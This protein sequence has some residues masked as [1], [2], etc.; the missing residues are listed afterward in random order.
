MKPTFRT[1]VLTAGVLLTALT[2]FAFSPP[3][4]RTFE[5]MKNLDIFATLFKE[6]NQYYVDDIN[7]NRAIRTGIEAMLKELDP[8]TV[9]YPEDDI[10]DYRTMTTGQYSGIGVVTQARAGKLMITNVL[11][12]TPAARAGLRIGDEIVKVDGVDIKRPGVQID[13]LMKG[14]TG[15][16]VKLSLLRLGQSALEEVTVG[17]DV[18]K[19][20][21]VPYYGM[22]DGQTGYLDL[23][24]FTATASKEIKD[25]VADLKAKGMKRLVLDLRENPGGLLLMAVDISNVFLPKELPVVETKGKIAEWNKVYKTTYSPLDTEL[26]LIVL[27]NNRSASAAEI[28]AGAIQDYDRGVLVG[29]RSFGKGL[30]QI[31]RDLSYNTKMKVTTAKYYIPSGRCIQAIDYS[32]RNPDGSVGKIPDSLKT[33]FQT[34]NSKRTVYDGGGILP[35]VAVERPQQAAIT[36]SLIRQNLIFDYANRYRQAHATVAPA[37]QF[38]LTDAEYQEFVKWLADKTYDYT[39]EVEQKVTELEASARK[40]GYYEA[41]QQQLTAL[42]TRFSHNKEND[43]MKFRREIQLLLEQEIVQRY[44]FQKGVREWSFENDAEIRAGLAV[45]N[46]PARYRAILSGSK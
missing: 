39:T 6:L 14:Q 16:S 22:I 31:G 11:E 9:F 2:L 42:K 8:Y 15:S 37:R 46:D 25:A 43:L 27:T 3:A 23:K 30:V 19:L 32:H 34:R 20:T 13:R 17:R 44:Y 7:P 24:G 18:V 10:E 38:K 4:D 28:V 33:A 1:P 45:L 41:V 35:D 29:Q 5:I 36:S 40:E 12:D 21:N 26:P